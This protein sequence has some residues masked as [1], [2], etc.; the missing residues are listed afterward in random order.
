M[1]NNSFM[2]GFMKNFMSAVF[3]V[4]LTVFLERLFR[5]VAL[6]LWRNQSSLWL[7]KAC[8]CCLW[9]HRAAGTGFTQLVAG[10]GRHPRQNVCR[11]FC[12]VIPGQ[13]LPPVSGTA[14]HIGNTSASPWKS[15][16]Y[17]GEPDNLLVLGA[18]AI[19]ICIG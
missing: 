6:W 17:P 19:P 10:L 11:W 2:E 5:P 7:R 14:G 4:P 13:Y 8:P 16:F 9:L 1:R 3:K 18:L 12:L 15:V